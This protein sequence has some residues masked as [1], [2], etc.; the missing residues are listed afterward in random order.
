MTFAEFLN[1]IG[2]DSKTLT[3]EQLK[4]LESLYADQNLGVALKNVV[5]ARDEAKK[6]AEETERKKKEFEDLYTGQFLPEMQKLTKEAVDAKAEAAS[7]KARL[8]AA[9]T[10]ALVDPE[11]KNQPQVPANPVP[12]SPGAPQFDEGRLKDDVAR[13]MLMIQ[14][15]S[16]KHQKLFGEPLV[17]SSSLAEK[18]QNERKLGR[19]VTLEQ[20][21]RNEFKVDAKEAELAAKRQA[22]HDKKVADEALAN[23]MKEHG[24]NPNLRAPRPSRHTSYTETNSA[25][26]PWK[27]SRLKGQANAGWREF[28]QRKLAEAHSS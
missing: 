22:D 10:Y 23:Y 12:G 21:W 11:I 18:F 6:L 8:Q 13:T 4:G 19:N 15:L 28:A 26:E 27:A 5:S 17:N 9:E 3:A 24:S 1:S 16:G 25:S 14:D 7:M 20:V 2:V